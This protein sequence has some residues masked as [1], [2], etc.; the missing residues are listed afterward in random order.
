MIKKILATAVCAL[1]LSCAA[2]AT[3]INFGIISTE[4]STNLKKDWEPVLA[5][6]AKQTGYDI[7]PFFAPDYAGVIEGMRFNKVQVAWFGN[8]SAMEA[9]DR[10]DGEIFAQTIAADGSAGY[11]SLLIVN[12]KSP[13]NT[14]DEMLKDGKSLSFSIG[15]PN[16]TSGFL[17]PSYYVF[18]KHN[19]DPK[20]FFK[21]TRSANHESNAMAV[22]NGQVDVATN[23]TESMDRLKMVHPT[24]FEKIKVIWTSPL[25]PSDPLVMRKDLPQAEK[26]KIA[27]FFFAYGKTPE[28]K[29]ALKRLGLSGFKPST[30]AQLLPIRQ[31]SLFTKRTKIAADAKLS[32]EERQSQVAKIDEQ[33]AA[34]K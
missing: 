23:N 29:Q 34:L 9:V 31:I 12:K 30:N 26:T 10:S 5:E 14:L 4:S 25:I 8:K 17:V 32:A 1:G 3:T 7:K 27:D 22:A 18:A 19:V 11:Y 33:L 28:Q 21:V 20:T 2:H 6:M 13:I 16:S 15:D 24:D